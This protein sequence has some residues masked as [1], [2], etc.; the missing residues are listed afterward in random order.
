MISETPWSSL[1]PAA[2]ERL[3]LGAG[4][5]NALLRVVIRPLD[6]TLSDHEANQLRDRMYAAVHRG[7]RHTWAAR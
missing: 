4:Q 7:S 6:H 5:R 2:S 1:P 3:G